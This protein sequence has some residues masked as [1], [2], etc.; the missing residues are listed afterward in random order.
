MFMVSHVHSATG[1]GPLGEA[2]HGKLTVLTP[3]LCRV[4][5]GLWESV[6]HSFRG[7]EN[8]LW[9]QGTART[10]LAVSR[11]ERKL[12]L[13]GS[14]ALEQPRNYWMLQKD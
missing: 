2:G 7:G 8:S 9:S 14:Q 5:V 6:R 3:C 12:G 1:L 4:D 13:S 10:D 11:P